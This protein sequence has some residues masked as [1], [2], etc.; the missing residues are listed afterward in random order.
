MKRKNLMFLLIVTLAALLAAPST[1]AKTAVKVY[2]YIGEDKEDFSY[3]IPNNRFL[4][5]SPNASGKTIICTADIAE[6]FAAINGSVEFTYDGQTF[7]FAEDPESPPGPSNPLLPVPS[8]KSYS[9]GGK[10]ILMPGIFDAGNVI[11]DETGKRNAVP[12]VSIGQSVEITGKNAIIKRSGIE[13][14]GSEDSD[15]KIKNL[16]FESCLFAAISAESDL[17]SLTI[18]DSHVNYLS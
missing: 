18:R 15:V 2:P 12:W 16:T 1:M 3:R 14:H 10:I 8:G 17:N 6:L 11:F 7:Y 4:R 9:G 13:I 5:G